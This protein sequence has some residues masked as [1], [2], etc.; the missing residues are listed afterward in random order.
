MRGCLKEASGASKPVK[1]L[2]RHAQ[3]NCASN[4]A[5]YVRPPDA[6][7]DGDEHPCTSITTR[8]SHPRVAHSK[9]PRTTGQRS[10][11]S[12]LRLEHGARV[13]RGL[14]LQA[15]A[16]AAAQAGRQRH[17]HRVADLAVLVVHRA[18]EAEGVR[19]ALHARARRVT[20]GALLTRAG[21]SISPAYLAPPCRPCVPTRT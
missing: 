2:G 17:R 13:A 1:T 5:H 9:Q 21:S 4:T 18:V 8:R 3:A 20:R 7:A 14:G 11:G 6:C 12:Q 16:Q 19:E 10:S 15:R